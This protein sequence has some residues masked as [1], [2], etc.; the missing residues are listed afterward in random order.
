MNQ[1]YPVIFHFFLFITLFFTIQFVINEFYISENLLY[2]HLSEN[3]SEA[4]VTHKVEKYQKFTPVKIIAPIVFYALRFFIIAI[5]VAVVLFLINIKHPFTGIVKAVILAEY[6]YI[7]KQLIK[8]I[9]FG[10]YRTDYTFKDFYDFN[11]DSVSG[12]AD[13]SNLPLYFRVPINSINLFTLLYLFVLAFFLKKELG[14]KNTISY[15]KSLNISLKAYG[16]GL[17]LWIV[18]VLFVLVGLN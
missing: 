7:I 6:L 10:I 12:W 15:I 14:K 9:W 13:I 3:F 16:S 17:I 4:S 1:Y 18:I 11:W 5:F 2:E 8:L